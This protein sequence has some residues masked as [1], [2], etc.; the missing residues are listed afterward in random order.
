MPSLKPNL[1]IFFLHSVVG[2]LE[3]IDSRRIEGWPEP[4][5]IFHQ[6]LQMVPY[7]VGTDLSNTPLRSPPRR[8]VASA[9]FL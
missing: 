4:T 1:R 6:N 2:K 9:I 8:D 3:I 7:P 5:G